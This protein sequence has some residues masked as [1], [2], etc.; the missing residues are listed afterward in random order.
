MCTSLS[1]LSILCGL[2]SLGT[3][4]TAFVSN[5][6]IYTKEPVLLPSTDLQTTVSFR[7]GLWRVC[8]TYKRINSTIGLPSP[9]CVLIQYSSWNDITH[10]DLGIR[11]SLDFTPA[12]ISKM[13]LTMPFEG[14]SIALMVLATLFGLIG[15]C[16]G[17]H[18]TLIACTLYTLGGFSLAVGLIIFASV[19]SDAYVEH[20]QHK[21]TIPSSFQS[22]T[23]SGHSL[24]TT[25]NLYSNSGG[26]LDSNPQSQAALYDYKYGWSFY[27]ATVSFIMSEITAIISMTVYLKRFSSVEDMVRIMVPGGDRKL[28]Q[29]HQ[30]CQKKSKET[31]IVDPSPLSTDMIKSPIHSN[32]PSPS[33]PDCKPGAV[34]GG[35][36]KVPDICTNAIHPKINR[37]NLV[38]ITVPIVTNKKKVCK[39]KPQNRYNTVGN[40][41]LGAGR[42]FNTLQPG[43]EPFS[44]TVQ[45]TKYNSLDR[46]TVGSTRYPQDQ[47]SSESS[48]SSILITNYKHNSAAIK[49]FNTLPHKNRLK[50][51]T[52]RHCVSPSD[53]YTSVSSS[54]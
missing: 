40:A 43:V 41:T 30:N 21:V 22:G 36:S 2:L 8:P 4:L 26:S 7:I 28:R 45:D 13:R 50:L 10:T 35:E 5:V 9:G 48:T 53:S 31:D 34:A 23:Q 42:R 15:H 25:K 11:S 32:T 38:G 52:Q 29:Y 20:A 3:L 33:I 37:D 27:V 14:V 17:D 18:K 12:F 47:T 16:N 24:Q 19:L 49:T 44:E 1:G 39:C 54:L 46:Y 51:D 6:W